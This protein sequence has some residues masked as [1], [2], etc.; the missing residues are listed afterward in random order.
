MCST[1]G[2]FGCGIVNALV[3]EVAGKDCVVH[4]S[5]LAVVLSGVSML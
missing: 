4:R 5:L 1:A 2:A 3:I